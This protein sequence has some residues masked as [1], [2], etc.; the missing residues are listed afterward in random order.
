MPDHEKESTSDFYFATSFYGSRDVNQCVLIST[1]QFLF[2][3]TVFQGHTLKDAL[4]HPAKIY[5]HS[6]PTTASHYKE[7]PIT[8]CLAMWNS[9]REM[10][11]SFAVCREVIV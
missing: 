6:K 2:C 1:L 7:A 5:R 8:Y 10:K 3:S 9:V 11:C 4:Y